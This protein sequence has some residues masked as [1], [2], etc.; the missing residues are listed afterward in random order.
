MLYRKLAPNFKSCQNSWEV[1]QGVLDQPDPNGADKAD[2]LA[3]YLDE[4][5][6]VAQ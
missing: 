5:M 6:F 4:L 3:F 2:E 1:G